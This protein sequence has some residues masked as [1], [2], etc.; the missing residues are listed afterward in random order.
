MPVLRGVVTP[1]I[2][3]R[4]HISFGLDNHHS[5]H[6][7]LF[8]LRLPYRLSSSPVIQKPITNLSYR[9]SPNM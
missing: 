8:L 9:L 7:S 6:T 2:F 1:S 5:S 4:P 3:Y